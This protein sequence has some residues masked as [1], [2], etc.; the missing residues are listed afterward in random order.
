MKTQPMQLTSETDGR[1]AAVAP[2]NPASIAGLDAC[3][4]DASLA[5]Q[6][7]DPGPA[8]PNDYLS[9]L[10]RLDAMRAKFSPVYREA[11]LTPFI[12]T[13]RQI[14]EKVLVERPPRSLW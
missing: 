4:E 5:A 12:N 7:D 10:G 8:E 1:L 3:I 6:D 9:L 11:M 13:L 2:I 14:G